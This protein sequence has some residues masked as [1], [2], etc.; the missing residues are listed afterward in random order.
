MTQAP[1]LKRIALSRSRLAASV[2]ALA[3]LVVICATPQLMGSRV[4][5]A[6]DALGGASPAWLW[7]ATALFAVAVGTSAFAWRTAFGACGAHI[8]RSEATARYAVGSLVNSVAPAKLGDALRVA[9]FARTLEGPDR[10]WTGGGVYA[11]IGAARA[12]VIAVLVV[13]AS[14]VGALPLWPVFVLCGSVVV[15]AVLAHRFRNAHTKIAHL[16]DGFAAL[17]QEPRLAAIVI[18]WAALGAAAHVA[19]ATAVAIALGV[20]HPLLAG[21]VIVPAMGLASMI[22]LTPGN[23]GITSGAVAVALQS[24]G[25]GMTQ[26]LSTGIAFHAVETVAGLSAGC[27]GALWLARETTQVQRWAP[28]VAAAAA[29]L[30]IAAGMGAIVF[31][32]V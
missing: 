32:M 12:I 17:E 5:D 15:L 6:V 22:P 23:V 30:T 14:V 9:L 29:C 7:T 20:P 4:R 16:L 26:A 11:A 28:R 27:L 3:I 24:R 1:T 10:I 2:A 13:G 19:A 18:G 8:C 21:L 31:E 25:I